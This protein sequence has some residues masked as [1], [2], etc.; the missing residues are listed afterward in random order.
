MLHAAAPA[1]SPPSVWPGDWPGL[2]A[3]GAWRGRPRQGAAMFGHQCP[4]VGR[5]PAVAHGQCGD[6]QLEQSIYRV[7]GPLDVVGPPA[8]DAERPEA[9]TSRS[10]QAQMGAAAQPI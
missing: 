1:A 3:A 9:D 8:R 7:R 10:P 6:T 5:L 2:V 4:S